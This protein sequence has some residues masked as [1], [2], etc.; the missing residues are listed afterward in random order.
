M[1]S[2]V[3]FGAARVRFTGLGTANSRLGTYSVLNCG[4]D[5]HG[6]QHRTILGHF[7]SRL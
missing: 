5:R 7:A 1:D 6:I 4:L 2:I 3:V